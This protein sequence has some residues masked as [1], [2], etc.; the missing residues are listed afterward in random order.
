MKR[1]LDKDR[2]A[3]MEDLNEG[4]EKLDYFESEEH[5]QENNW[6]YQKN[7]NPDWLKPK[8]KTTINKNESSKNTQT[9]NAENSK[10]PIKQIDKKTLDV[11]KEINDIGLKFNELKNNFKLAVKLSK[12]IL[13]SKEEEKKFNQVILE[14]KNNLKEIMIRIK[15]CEFAIYD[16][17]T[18][19]NNNIPKN[20]INPGEINNCS[21][22]VDTAMQSI[23][24]EIK[25][26][27]DNNAPD[28]IDSLIRVEN[29]QFN[30]QS[31][32]FIAMNNVIDYSKLIIKLRIMQNMN[33][34]QVKQD[35]KINPFKKEQE[36]RM[37]LIKSNDVIEY[38]KKNGK[39]NLK[40]LYD[41]VEEE[42]KSEFPD[43]SMKDLNS[44]NQK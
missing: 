6:Q 25:S 32:Y 13:E 29:E 4:I 18:N 17:K 8:I 14:I 19:K 38:L 7:E 1:S 21:A 2:K 15:R 5:P 10:Q 24:V 37:F 35:Y 31:I 16:V 44:Y 26:F 33:P 28:W 20:I 43:F 40:T 41:E 11:T 39:L 3:L 42:L 36:N 23:N 34:Q 27:N 12:L 30:I 22:R 9:Q